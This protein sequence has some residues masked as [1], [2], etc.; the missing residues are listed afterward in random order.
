MV[1]S[2]CITSTCKRLILIFVLVQFAQY[3]PVQWFLK[4]LFFEVPQ[5]EPNPLFIGRQWLYSEIA[6]NILSDLSNNRGVIINGTP[7]SGKTA[8]ILQLVDQSCFG[9]GNSGLQGNGINIIE[10]ICLFIHVF[11]SDFKF[12]K[13]RQK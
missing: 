2:Y 12:Q 11:R 6:D 10:I 7:G 8:I 4:P 5:R 1:I 9:R 3:R 13:S